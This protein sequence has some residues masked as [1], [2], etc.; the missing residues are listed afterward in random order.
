MKRPVQIEI[1]MHDVSEIRIEHPT[2]HSGRRWF[3]LKFVGSDGSENEMSVW[4]HNDRAPEL[5]IEDDV[6][7]R[8][9]QTIHDEEQ[10]HA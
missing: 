3:V 10:D 5:V 1:T 2:G 8:R 6:S 4:S 9:V 7:V